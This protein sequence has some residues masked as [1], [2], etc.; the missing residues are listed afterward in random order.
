MFF[1]HQNARVL[2]REPCGHG[3]G[4]GPNFLG[5]SPEPNFQCARERASLAP[6]MG[7]VTSGHSVEGCGG[8]L[9]SDPRSFMWEPQMWYGVRNIGYKVTPSF[10]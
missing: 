6:F 1:I 7:Q 4:T 2:H 10:V 8:Q 5:F 3:P 9:G